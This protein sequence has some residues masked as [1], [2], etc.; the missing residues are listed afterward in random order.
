MK[1][2]AAMSLPN[3]R[4]RVQSSIGHWSVWALVAGLGVLE[5]TLTSA[6]G[7][8][9]C[10]VSTDFLRCDNLLEWFIE[11]RKGCIYIS[12]ITAKGYK[13]ESA[14]GSDIQGEVWEGPNMMLWS[15]FLAKS[16]TESLFP[17]K[18]HDDT[19]EHCQARQL[20]Q[21]SVSRAFPGAWSHTDDIL[22]LTFS[23]QP[24]PEVQPKA[25]SFQRSSRSQNW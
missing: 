6:C 21:A 16:W 17:A 5:T 14:K 11:L 23:L 20:T 18:I 9:N 3:S 2:I 12:F 25:F 15:S 7:A 22:G 13:S 4:L 8:T 1:H 24:C 10:G 19:Q